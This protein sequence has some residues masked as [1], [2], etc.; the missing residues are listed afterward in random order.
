MWNLINFC[1][2]SNWQV[3]AGFELNFKLAGFEPSLDVAFPLNHRF[4]SKFDIE[5]SENNS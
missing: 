4:N 3:V 2:N 5:I 1:G